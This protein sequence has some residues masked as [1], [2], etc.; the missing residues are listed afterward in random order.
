[1]SNRKSKGTFSLGRGLAESPSL[2]YGTVYISSQSDM[3]VSIEH[4]GVG[5][6]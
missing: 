1:M 6:Q 3:V 5:G 2:T 4:A